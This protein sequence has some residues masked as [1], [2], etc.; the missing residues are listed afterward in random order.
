MIN[1]AA[2]N[3]YFQSVQWVSFGQVQPTVPPPA[4]RLL[5]GTRLDFGFWVNLQSS[6]VH[7]STCTRLLRQKGGLVHVWCMSGACLM[8]VVGSKDIQ[9]W[10]LTDTRQDTACGEIMFVDAPT[11]SFNDGGKARTMTK[12]P[13]HDTCTHG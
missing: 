3:R 1:Q 5:A 13:T 7:D 8:H 12:T 11:H 2:L 4:A 10:I 6:W 9:C